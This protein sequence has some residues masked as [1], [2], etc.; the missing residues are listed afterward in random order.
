MKY[1]F[2]YI[3][4][5]HHR[6][7]TAPPRPHHH[8]NIMPPKPRKTALQSEHRMQQYL[9][10]VES[11]SKC[12]KIE[13]I[14]NANELTAGAKV[15]AT[16][17][18]LY[19]VK[20]LKDIIMKDGQFKINYSLLENK[21]RYIADMRKI[22]RS[23]D[24]SHVIIATDD[25]R[26]GEFIAWSICDIFKL[27]VETTPRIIFHEITPTAIINAMN[28]PS[29]VNMPMVNAQQTRT[30]L[31]LLIGF[32]IS[33]L[34]WKH[35]LHDANDATLSAGRCQTPALRLIYEN[36]KIMEQHPNAQIGTCDFGT[37]QNLGADVTPPNENVGY[38][39]MTRI[40]GEQ[41]T[42][43][44]APPNTDESIR[45]FIKE[46]I[47]FDATVPRS[48]Q[49]KE[50][51]IKEVRPPL[52]FNTSSLL[53][54]ASALL[55]FSP[56]LTMSL[57]QQLYQE[58]HITYMRTESRQLS[59][60]F[61]ISAK[62]YIG[63]MFGEQYV[64]QGATIAPSNASRELA[65]EAIRCTHIEMTNYEG[66]PSKNK[67]YKLIWKHS[68]CVLMK[69]A[70][71]RETMLTVPSY[72]PTHEWITIRE[73]TIFVG[74]RILDTRTP[75]ATTGTAGTY[76]EPKTHIIEEIEFISIM[77][78]KSTTHYTEA[79]L[80]KKLEE[81][82]IGRPSTFHTLVETI[83]ERNYVEQT[84]IEG[85][86]FEQIKY[87]WKMKQGKIDRTT[88]IK[89]WGEE[90]RK[91]KITTLGKRTL[92][93]LLDYFDP[94]FDYGYTAKMETQ[95]DE[96]AHSTTTLTPRTLC[97]DCLTEI[98]KCA[99]GVKNEAITLPND[100]NYEIYYSMKGPLVRNKTNHAE[101]Y[102]LSQQMETNQIDEDFLKKGNYK[103]G[104]IIY[105]PLLGTH[106]N[107]PIFGRMG[108]FGAYLQYGEQNIS[109]RGIVKT[110]EQL[111]KLTLEN[112][113]NIIGKSLENGVS[114]ANRKVLRVINN[115]ISI[116]KGKYAKPYIYYKTA[117]MK[118]PQFIP[119]K[120]F[121]NWEKCTVEEFMQV[122]HLAKDTTQP[123]PPHTPRP[124]AK[125]KVA[126]HAHNV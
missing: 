3:H 102:N 98:K 15:I 12:Q 34:L 66:N 30:V 35:L 40:N 104:D 73:D 74:F 124:T 13:S 88:E 53:Q 9:V 116:R 112:A 17:G 95:L 108:K 125:G 44:P 39:A 84:D 23:A 106:E 87:N 81:L 86:P 69:N 29:V 48:P 28:S 92:E 123:T 61:S 21:T 51:T 36:D 57:A 121:A 115:E 117:E 120:G 111:E 2:S 1:K 16:K 94:L 103:L 41:Y 110:Q 56:K 76:N 58:G 109:L 60:H 93:F 99:K 77:P 75:I 7:T 54:Q 119:I 91:L 89:K 72:M 113:V 5:I 62:Q 118:E 42:L 46:E 37:T 100:T 4:Y 33:P 55:Q 45:T 122:F 49:M 24:I 70:I 82:G 11:P 64:L 10:L 105:N 20:G 80:I 63:R 79:S 27:P 14:L 96:I 50:P 126:S 114:P 31:D 68:L 101:I 47:A 43:F 65:H 38:K 83:K 25:D 71:I 78:H 85:V 59:Q 32:K 8:H 97:N 90:K 107:V 22:I 19:C 67:L 52:P 18:H 6:I 26:E